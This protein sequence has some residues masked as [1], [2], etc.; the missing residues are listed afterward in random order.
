MHTNFGTSIRSDR[1]P[2]PHRPRQHHAADRTG[3]PGDGAGG[4][5][6]PFRPP[7]GVTGGGARFD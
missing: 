7:D 5:S 2:R 6:H 1:R 3:R 4:P